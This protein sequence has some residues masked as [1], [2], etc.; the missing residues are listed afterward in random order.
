MAPDCDDI[1]FTYSAS[2]DYWGFWR[3]IGLVENNSITFA[4]TA[5]VDAAGTVTSAWS[6]G[7]QPQYYETALGGADDAPETSP[8]TPPETPSAAGNLRDS[9]GPGK[10]SRSEITQLLQQ[11][12]MEPPDTIFDSDPCQTA[13]YAPGKVN[14]AALQ[15]AVNRPPVCP[16]S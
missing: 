14:S 4:I 10:L 12:P 3:Q 7:Y 13:P 15:A 5:V 6:G 9:G 11:N 1:I 16:P 2:G 8:E